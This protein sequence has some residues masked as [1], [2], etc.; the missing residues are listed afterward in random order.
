MAE[1][2]NQ[3][4]GG[5]ERPRVG[6]WRWVFGSSLLYLLGAGPA[7]RVSQAGLIPGPFILSLYAPV[8][9]VCYHVPT[10]ESVYD[11]YVYGLWR[12]YEVR[13]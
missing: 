4:S 5:L 12:V 11:W 7:F 1:A 3:E 2:Q 9:I 8:R 6:I 10:A 13:T